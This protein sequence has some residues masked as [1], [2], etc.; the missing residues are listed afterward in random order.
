MRVLCAL[1]LILESVTIPE[2]VNELKAVDA[3][4]LVQS[5]WNSLSARCTSL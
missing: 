5:N 2:G 4:I 1:G 3:A